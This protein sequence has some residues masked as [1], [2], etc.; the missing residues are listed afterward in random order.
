MNNH[1]MHEEI[2]KRVIYSGISFVSDKIKLLVSRR[3]I[4]IRTRR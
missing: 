1:T 4:I 2:G 3:G